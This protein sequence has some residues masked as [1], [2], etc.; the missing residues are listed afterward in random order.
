MLEKIASTKIED[1]WMYFSE[2]KAAE[3]ATLEVEQVLTLLPVDIGYS[4]T[5][6]KSQ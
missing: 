1:A 4:L 5:T 3:E 6:H 2:M